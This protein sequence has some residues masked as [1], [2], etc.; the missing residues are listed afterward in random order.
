ML[1]FFSPERA[2]TISIG[3][4]PLGSVPEFIAG[5]RGV[6]LAAGPPSGGAAGAAPRVAGEPG[7]AP[8]D[9]ELDPLELDGCVGEEPAPGANGDGPPGGVG[10]AAGPEVG[11]TISCGMPLRPPLPGGA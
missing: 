9:G 8:C 6:V 1:T 7:D 5:L 10:G 4:E 2:F 11:E 3:D